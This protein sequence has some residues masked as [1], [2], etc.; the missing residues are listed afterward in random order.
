MRSD[1][2][3]LLCER[4]RRLGIGPPPPKGEKKKRQADEAQDYEDWAAGGK[5]S[6]KKSFYGLSRRTKELNENLTPLLNFL[7][8]NI[9]RKWDDV[10]SEIKASCPSEGAVNAHIYQHLFQF[11][12]KDA[13]IRNGIPYTPP[14]RRFSRYG[15]FKDE[16]LYRLTSYRPFVQFYVDEKGI[17]RP[18]PTRQGPKSQK[19]LEPRS[20]ATCT[21]ISGPST[22]TAF[23]FGFF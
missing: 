2:K 16:E 3:K 12:E 20:S 15:G 5:V 18:A 11:V 4:E 9:G 7:K 23:G 10:Y 19:P 1:F 8:K 14:H 13:V 21:R 6:M 22:W 17:L